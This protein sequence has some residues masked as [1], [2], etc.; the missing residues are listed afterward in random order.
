MIHNASVMGNAMTQWPLKPLL[1]IRCDASHHAT[2]VGPLF[3]RWQ[4]S[5][6]RHQGND[7]TRWLVL[8]MVQKSQRTTWDAYKKP[9]ENNGISCTINSITVLG[10]EYPW[11][12]KKNGRV[13]YD[14]SY[15][16]PSSW[17]SLNTMVPWGSY[18]NPTRITVS[19]SQLHRILSAENQVPETWLHKI[20][21]Q[22]NPMKT[23]WP[24]DFK[25]MRKSK[26]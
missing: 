23:H 19:N 16:Y 11:K 21:C 13:F 8:L 6:K 24:S 10:R 20:T 14:I 5:T 17:G 7:N 3:A 26:N 1:Q 9:V 2:A 4:T 15:N 12:H 18:G 22:L 25:D